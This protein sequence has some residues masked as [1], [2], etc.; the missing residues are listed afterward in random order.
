MTR[1]KKH[2]HEKVIK[3]CCLVFVVLGPIKEEAQKI[4]PAAGFVIF[5]LAFQV[6][7]TINETAQ[8]KT[9]QHTTK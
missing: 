5:L 7:R 9:T 2:N 3:S 1:K 6:A 8:Q 4:D